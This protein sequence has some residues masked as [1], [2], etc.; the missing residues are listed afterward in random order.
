[1]KQQ[2]L[3]AHSPT[4]NQCIPKFIAEKEGKAERYQKQ[5][6][7][8]L[9]EFGDLFGERKPNEVTKEEMRAFINGPRMNKRKP[10]QE[11]ARTT[12]HNLY[13]AVCAFYAYCLAEKWIMQNPMETVNAP[14][15]AK[16]SPKI[17]TIDEAQKLLDHVAEK[18]IDM[19]GFVALGLFCGIRV[20][21]LCRMRISDLQL[22]SHDSKP[23][24]LLEESITKTKHPRNVRIP[25]N[26]YV[27]LNLWLDK[28]TVWVSRNSPT[29]RPL[30]DSDKIIP[31]G[32]V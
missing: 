32:D 23:Y 2:A 12:R 31:V 26:C 6:Q 24:A 7:F 4:I 25:H 28:A 5:L 16:F 21:E 8:V 13:R 11:I 3:T 15:A 18:H 22:E 27:W 14:T 10:G 30:K 20:Q 17:L 29:R 1:M 19:L 9:K